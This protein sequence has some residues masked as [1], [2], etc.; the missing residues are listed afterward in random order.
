MMLLKILRCYYFL[1]L[2]LLI[3]DELFRNIDFTKRRRYVQL[4]D[5]VK[6][7]GGIVR[8]FSSMHASG[9]RLGQLTGIAAILRF[10]M[11]DLDLNDEHHHHHE[12]HDEQYDFNNGNLQPNPNRPD[13]NFDN[14]N[15]DDDNDD[16][17]DDDDEQS[18]NN[19]RTLKETR[20]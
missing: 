1:Y 5:S 6:E 15:D 19:D 13:H 3:T 12:I 14:T 20:A 9:E 7:S 4:V 2:D 18:T 8:L 10:P 11:P 17:D 16:D